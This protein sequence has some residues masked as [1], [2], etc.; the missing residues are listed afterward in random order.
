MSREILL[1]VDALARE[2]NVSRDVVFG[3]LELALASA[4]KKRFSEDV[5]VR[6]AIDRDTGSYEA[7]RRWKVV[8]DDTPEYNVAQMLSLE[9][10][11]DRKPD[12]KLDDY[13][14]APIENV[15]F[16]RIGAQ[17]AKQVILQR[18]RDA[19]R[20]QILNDFLSRGDELV[21]GT[22][23][24]M[25]RGS[26]IVESG[27]L[28]AQ[29]PRE[30][31]IPKENLRVGDRV[32]AWVMKIDR[33]ARGPQLILSR[34]APQFI[35]KLFELEVPEI[36]EGLLEIK[37]AARDPGVRAKIAVHTNDRRIDPIG[38]CVGMRGSRVQAVTQELA[39]ERVDIVL[40]SADPA[41]FVIGALAPAEVSSILVDEEKHAM[42]VVVDEENLAIAIGRSGQNVRLA[43][44]LTGWSIN[45]MTQEESTKK[46]EEEGTRVKTLFME[47][48]DVDE[49]VADILIQ[50]GFSTLEEVAYVP[51]NE[52]MEIDAFDENTVNE[53]RSRARNSL[54]VQAIASEE[55]IDGVDPNLLQLEGMDTQLA[56][57]LAAQG[58]K[59]RDD[60][61]DLAVD[62]L[63]ELT[64]MDAERAKGLIIAARAHWF[65][66][67]PAAGPA[68]QPTAQ[69]ASQPPLQR[70]GVQ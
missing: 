44:E 62:E 19:E 36:E 55:S 35:M 2:K 25:E 68:A 1:L 27:R 10:A 13:I 59:T 56:A 32:R 18:I 12:A 70:K 46:Q 69:P 16:G 8:L 48:L 37:S 63:S 47:R 52:M 49:E 58:V 7:F 43:S 4:T 23:K 45:L 64:G 26:A 6:V 65:A 54:L 14:E 38:T 66:D 60:L 39:G 53:L 34:T 28:E 61:A 33:G 17:T 41:T 11:Q 51:I 9:E 24:R 67:E 15:P 42:D 20:E 50:E 29:L 21:T 3:A 57:K 40:W 31:M 5:D 22:V 30:H